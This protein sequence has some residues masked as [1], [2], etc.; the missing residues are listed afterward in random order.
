MAEYLEPA[1]VST[2]DGIEDTVVSM[3]AAPPV[4]AISKDVLDKPTYIV[5]ATPLSMVGLM[6]PS[7][8]ARPTP[9]SRR[10][11]RPARQR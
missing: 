8:R 11:P 7:V 1:V 4:K 2:T 6:E 3:D 10:L 9:L 5:T